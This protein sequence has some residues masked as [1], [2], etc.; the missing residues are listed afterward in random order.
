M[1][2][3]IVLESL[4]LLFHLPY[5]NCGKTYDLT[6]VKP[7]FNCHG[8]TVFD[9]GLTILSMKLSALM[10]TAKAMRKTKEL[11]IMQTNWPWLR[12]HTQI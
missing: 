6:M 10:L 2:Q 11:S 3:T 7:W 1:I 12:K 8:L 5:K 4:L 9:H